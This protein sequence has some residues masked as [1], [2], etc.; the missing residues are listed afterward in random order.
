VQKDPSRLT[1]MTDDPHPAVHF[2]ARSTPRHRGPGPA[3]Q[4]V[5]S[6]LFISVFSAM[7]GLGIIVPLLPVY[8]ESLGASGIW[9]GVIFAAFAFSRA[10]FMPV[11][12]AVSDRRGRRAFV[13]AGLLLYTV[14][15]VAYIAATNVVFLTG[16]RFLH[17]LASAMVIPVAMA[18]VADLA[19][20]GREGRVMGTFMVS[21]FL[22]MGFGPLIGGVIKDLFGMN[23]VFLAMSIFSAISLVTSILFLP[24]SA[25]S[26]KKGIPLRTTLKNR[27]L[28]PV[29]FFRV[30][31]AFA[32]G[33]FMVFFPILAAAPLAIAAI[34]GGSGDAVLTSGEIGVIISASILAT[35][36]LQRAFGRLADRHSKPLLILA[37]SLIVSAAL[38]LMP[39]LHGFLPLFVLAV[40]FGVG[41]GMAIPASTSLVTIAGRD[42]GQ[43][44]AMGAFNTAMS[45]GMVTAPLFFGAVYDL[46]GVVWV[47]VGGAVISGL[48]AILF[49]AMAHRSGIR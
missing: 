20:E 16:V 30:M 35:A 5:F 45:V 1:P 19:P 13:L 2:P 47:F 3:P 11:I 49:Y 27:I 12:G 15:S 36:L 21:M 37:G 17:G 10:L 46:A 24:E 39:F 32:N 22:G 26:V 33:T 31:N 41:S 7:L 44:A 40:V 23:A 14:L 18:Y 28:R 29:L 4:R 43:G 34:S 9:I 8:A 42:T 48:S 25:G 6:V 38:L